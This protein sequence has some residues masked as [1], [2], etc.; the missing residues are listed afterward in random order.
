MATR[1]KQRD[2]ERAAEKGREGQ[3][4]Q[5]LGRQRVEDGA[6]WS[7]ALCPSS[8]LRWFHTS[9]YCH[10]PWPWK[11]REFRVKAVTRGHTIHFLQLNLDRRNR[12]RIGQRIWIVG[13]T[14]VSSTGPLKCGEMPNIPGGGTSSQSSHQNEA[15]FQE[16]R[17]E[18]SPC[19]DDNLNTWCKSFSLKQTPLWRNFEKTDQ[20]RAISENFLSKS[21][22]HPNQVHIHSLDLGNF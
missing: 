18:R 1:K 15:C 20:F 6:S 9:P 7:D 22:Y 4:W 12:K 17:I 10:P 5:Q 21:H 13:P 8:L 11:L 14:F 16:Q 19:R 3:L 2:R